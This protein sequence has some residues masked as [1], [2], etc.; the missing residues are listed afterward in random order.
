MKKVLLISTNMEKTPTAIFPLGLGYIQASLLAAGY[1]AGIMD[2]AHLTWEK[3]IFQEYM[4]QYNPDIIAIAVRNLDNCC[5]QRPRSF[6]GQVVQVIHWIRQCNPGMPIIMGGSG[7]SLLPEEWLATVGADYG[8][9]GD[10]TDSMV[11][12]V[13][14]LEKQEDPGPIP[15]LIY[16]GN[17]GWIRNPPLLEKNLDKFPFPK[18]DGYIH[19]LAPETSVK[20]NIQ[21]K[22]GC[23]FQ[24]S[25]CSY[26]SLE[27]T[28]VRIRSPQ[29]V[30]KEIREL[31]LY[32]KVT[33]FDF[34]DSL[35]NYPVGH[36]EEICKQ[37]IK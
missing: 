30:I 35:F 9:V 4:Q 7:F 16:A 2:L 5:M 23:P 11:Q 12:L 21:T 1:E 24:C 19:P 18:R 25:Y 20:H 14:K 3:S 10:G 13:S 31:T 27:G 8:I 29:N 33:S 26:S 15:G 34:V 17:G 6:V 37:I 28:G 36:A 32:Y 22:R